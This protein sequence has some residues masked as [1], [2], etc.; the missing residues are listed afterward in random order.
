[1]RLAGVCCLH[2]EGAGQPGGTYPA[3]PHRVG[4]RS[5]PTEQRRLSYPF[6]CPGIAADPCAPGVPCDW[7]PMFGQL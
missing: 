6:G 2:A 3:S 1:M 5:M 4:N 7:P